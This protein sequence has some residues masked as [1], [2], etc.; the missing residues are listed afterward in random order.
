MEIEVHGIEEAAALAAALE[1][2][3]GALER[4][5]LEDG[6]LEAARAVAGEARQTAGFQDRTGALRNSIRARRGTRRYKPSALVEADA[7]HAQLVELGTVSAAAQPFLGPAVQATRPGQ[8]KAFAA[9]VRK[10]FRRVE[11]ELAG[12]RRV[13]ARTR[14][15]LAA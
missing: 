7:P 13:S 1:A 5:A 11:R 4:V 14:R 6:L 10:N 8:L 2:L 15:A 3:P 9:G 12:H